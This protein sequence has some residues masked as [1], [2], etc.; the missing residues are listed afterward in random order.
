MRRYLIT[1]GAKT[2]AGGT[3]VDGLR[4]FGINGVETAL[5]GHEVRCPACQTAGAIVC[6]GPRLKMD[7]H[8]RKV[9]LSDDICLC[10]C[11]PAPRLITDQF[12]RYQTVTAEDTSVLSRAAPVSPPTQASSTTPRTSP[13]SLSRPATPTSSEILESSCERNWRFY[14]KQAEDIVASGGTLIADPRLRNRVINSAYARL[15]R[16][17]KRFQWAGLAA[18]KLVALLRSNHF[19]YITDIP[20]GA[21]QALEL[22]LASQCSTFNDRRTVVFSQHPF[23][24]LADINQRMAFVLKAAAQFDDLL[25]G[26]EL[27]LIEQAIEDIAEGRGVL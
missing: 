21:A 5:E 14:Q 24:N 18:T 27:Q 7:A 2:T 3:V 22:T 13:T 10:K 8:G 4:G 20:S 1:R 26:A 9:A 19:S 23:A 12:D 25:H 6:V 15:W 16:L 17:D 11:D